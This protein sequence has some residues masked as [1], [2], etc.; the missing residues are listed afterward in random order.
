MAY[1]EFIDSLGTAWKVWNTTPLPGAV[2][3][4]EMRKGWLTFESMACS[5]RRLAPVPDS[6]EHLSTEDLEQLCAQAS[7]VRHPTI[8]D[9]G[10]DIAPEHN[11]APRARTPNSNPNS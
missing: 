9:A 7:H 11:D 3:T 6:W 2:L 1:R 5:L 8:D 4:S 10:L